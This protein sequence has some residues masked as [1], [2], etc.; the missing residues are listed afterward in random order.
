MKKY[1][2]SLLKLNWVIVLFF[3][4]GAVD[5][6]E[7]KLPF[8]N[9]CLS[10]E[11]RVDDLVSRMTLEEKI[12]QMKE[13]APAIPRLGIPAYNWWN[14]TLHGVAR[15][16]DTVTVFPQAIALAAG[17]DRQAIQ[18]MGEICATE[19]R[20][21]YNQAIKD[22]ENGQRYKGL[23]FWTPNVNIF[24][25]PRWGRGQETYGEDPYLTGQLGISIVK[26]LQGNDSRYLKTSACAKHF[27]VHSGPEPSRHTFD[28]DVSD[29]D[30]W[31]TYLPA[32]RDLIVD[33]KVSSVMCAY[34]R[35]RGTPCCGNKKLMLDIL[36]NKWGFQGYVTSDCGAIIDFWTTHKTSEDQMHA[37]ADAVKVGTDLECGSFWKK[38]WTYNALT[39]AIENDLIDEEKLDESVKRLFMTRMRL[40]M[41]DENVPFNQIPYAVLN[42]H[43]HAEHAL[44]MARQSMVLLKNKGL[45]PLH[46]NIKTIAVVGPNAD[47]KKMLLGNY[48]GIPD[49]IITAL[50]GIKQ[51][52]GSKVNVI[53]DKG[54]DYTKLIKGK[55][56][57]SVSA[58]M[59]DADIIVFVGGIS[60]SLEGEEGEAG[61]VPGFYKGDRTSIALP[62]VQ[63][64]MMKA[65]KSTGKPLVYVNMSGSAMGMEWEAENADAIIQAW[66]GGQSAGTALADVLFGDYNPS[67]RL[68]VTFYKND[69]DLPDF[70]D[71][72]MENRTY[73]YFKGVPQYEFGF[74]LSYTSFAY[75]KLKVSELNSGDTVFTVQIE[76]ENTGEMAG[77]EVVQLYVSPKKNKEGQAIRTLKGFQRIH[78]IP[79]EKKLVSFELK[80]TDLGAYT[81]Q[82]D[83][84]TE[85]AK[86]V[87]SVGGS[88]ASK[89]SYFKGKSIQ[90][91][92]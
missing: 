85:A 82:G 22:G 65:L 40:G 62:K 61:G 73:R 36:R 4:I 84:N 28:V 13:S 88:Q 86:Y 12:G 74:G 14:E 53:Y 41:F 70:S 25:D 21:I 87:I 68:P 24:R 35:F 91:C 59:A 47:N 37:S 48:N 55:S 11:E 20:A 72:N 63:T 1:K 60:P 3:M 54:V 17:F 71:Y 39:E 80:A 16:K 30:L 56:I 7:T 58:K 2:V 79:G 92:L 78:L 9:S 76:V 81:E 33:A 46:K 44:A 49:E 10:F 27:A 23:T 67:G 69:S 83:I 34:N 26:G 45:L 75:N 57:S 29:Y 18:R 15:S 8:E 38:E 19:A 31:N 89:S 42:A 77:D 51:K 5:A 50:T 64:D 52:L 90:N 66:Y 32:F 43:E 6:Q